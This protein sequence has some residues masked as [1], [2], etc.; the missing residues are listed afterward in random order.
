MTRAN[1]LRIGPLNLV[2]WLMP[3]TRRDGSLP[4]IPPSQSINLQPAGKVRLIRIHRDRSRAQDAPLERQE[5]DSVTRCRYIPD[6]GAGLTS[7]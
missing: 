3:E 4:Q 1:P 5:F 7:I 2:E 6:K